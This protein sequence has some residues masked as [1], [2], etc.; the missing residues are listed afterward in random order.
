MSED[1]MLD[2]S[3]AA[4]LK[5]AFRRTRGS[6]G[7]LWTNGTIKRLSE[8]A[9]LGNVLDVLQGRSKIVP[10]V[11][12]AGGEILEGDMD[13]VIRTELNVENLSFRSGFSCYEQRAGGSLSG[14]KVYAA[15]KNNNLLERCLDLRDGEDIK[16]RGINFFRKYFKLGCRYKYA[17]WKSVVPSDSGDLV[18]S[19]LTSFGEKVLIERQF[20]CA[21]FH[22][23]LISVIRSV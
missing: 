12:S 20:L 13:P 19:Y 5:A 2:V 17:L 10:V 15:I 4:E 21:I 6:N 3:Q 23:D 1:L 8:G 9:V 22:E 11:L 16:K 7:S 18:F 14:T